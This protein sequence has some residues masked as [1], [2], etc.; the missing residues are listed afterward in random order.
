MSWLATS[1]SCMDYVFVQVYIK[2]SSYKKNVR[3]RTMLL[4]LVTSDPHSYWEELDWKQVLITN[5]KLY[6]FPT[7]DM[8][9]LIG[10]N[11]CSSYFPTFS[12]TVCIHG[13][14]LRHMTNWRFEFFLMLNA[15]LL[16]NHAW[17]GCTDTHRHHLVCFCPCF[18]VCW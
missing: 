17:Y 5:P 13:S 4:F 6:Q 11:W 15:T 1:T 8:F 9:R 3:F 14:R 10:C 18:L 2:L 12:S 7:W 16:N